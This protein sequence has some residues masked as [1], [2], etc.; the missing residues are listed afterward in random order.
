MGKGNLEGLRFFL[1]NCDLNFDYG[2]CIA[3]VHL[4]RLS[5]RSIGM[6]RGEIEIK[7]PEAYNWMQFG[8][9]GAI[10]NMSNV[11]QKIQGIRIPKEPKTSIILGAIDGGNAYNS[12]ASKATLKLEIRS[13]DNSIVSEIYEEIQGILGEVSSISETDAEFKVLAERQSGGLEYGDDLIKSVRGIMES[14]ELK[15][16]VSPTVGCLSAMVDAGIPGVTLGLTGGKKPARRRGR[17]S[18]CADV[19]RHHSTPRSYETHGRKGR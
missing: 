8:A 17:N 10:S 3:G 4:G 14:L 2:I 5:Y 1:E 15:P 12:P 18:N 9:S 19:Y 7:V 13:E 16:K 6:I 11:I